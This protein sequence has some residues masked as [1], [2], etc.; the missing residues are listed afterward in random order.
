[1]LEDQEIKHIHFSNMCNLAQL[2]LSGVHEFGSWIINAE[3]N[4]SF[5]D[6]TIENFKKSNI[7]FMISYN[8]VCY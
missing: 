4:M 1:M 8:A 3:I 7:R 2:F 5:R 6:D